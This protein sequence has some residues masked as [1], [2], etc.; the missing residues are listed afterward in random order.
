MDNRTVALFAALGATTIYGLNH[1]IAKVVMPHFV[2]PFAFILLRVV[3]AT[4]L[5]WLVSPWMPK[6]KIDRKDYFRIF[7]ASFFGMCLNML[8]FFKGLQLSTPINSGVI[9]TM[10]PIIILILSSL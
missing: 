8:M 4:L 1:T 7:V 9:V 6:E 2:G 3:G 5:F 10:T